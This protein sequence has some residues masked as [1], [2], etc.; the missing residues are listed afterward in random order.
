MDSHVRMTEKS[1]NLIGIASRMKNM[2]PII[3]EFPHI[4]AVVDNGLL[5][6]DMT[7]IKGSIRNTLALRLQ[8]SNITFTLRLAE[9]DEIKP[10]L[11]NKERFEL[12]KTNYKAFGK[13]SEMLHLEL[14]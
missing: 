3:K 8:N 10:I 7:K 5:L 2:A 12:L 9:P 1:P 11:T 13:L 14:N 6:D 4:E